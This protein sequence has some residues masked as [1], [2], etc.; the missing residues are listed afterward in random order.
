MSISRR[1]LFTF[2]ISASAAIGSAALITSWPTG[3]S[4]AAAAVGQPAP[5]FA[6]A[7]TSRQVRKLSEFRGKIVVLEWTSPSCPFV[8]AHYKSDNMQALQRWAT[9]QG[10]IWLSVLSTHPSRSDYLTGPQAAEF[11]KQRNAAPTA[12]LMDEDGKLGMSYG[13][14][15]TPHMFVIATDGALAYAGAIDEGPSPDPTTK[16]N[17]VR[18]AIED[19][20][21]NRPV[22]TAST[23]SYGCG[24]GYGN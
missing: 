21:A 8:G 3:V 23:R 10:V 4:A 14:R 13:A 7:D 9:Q 6:V 17:Y 5:D 15:T 18:S 22:K 20:M 16:R 1:R 24:V 2:V 12:F 11:N 19:L